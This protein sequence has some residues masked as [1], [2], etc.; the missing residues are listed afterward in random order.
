MGKKGKIMKSVRI[1]D[2][3]Y[4]KIVRNAKANRRTISGT[5]DLLIDYGLQIGPMASAMA[6]AAGAASPMTGME[7]PEPKYYT[8]EEFNELERKRI[9]AKRAAGWKPETSPDMSDEELM[10]VNQKFKGQE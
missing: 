2:E 1:S 6:S 5:I 10:A 9:E 4:V 8:I 3:T 7:I